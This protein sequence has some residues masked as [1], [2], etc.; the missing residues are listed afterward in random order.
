M[1]PTIT[2][3]TDL[4]SSSLC[5]ALE[6]ACKSNL[7]DH[8]YFFPRP[9][10][11]YKFLADASLGHAVFAGSSALAHLVEIWPFDV[12]Y[13][14]ETFTPNDTDLFL[15]NRPEG[16]RHKNFLKNIDIV[17]MTEK[18]VEELLMNFD[19]PICRVAMDVE[20]SIWVS[21]QALNAIM[22]GEYYIP[23][24]FIDKTEFSKLLRKHQW[25]QNTLAIPDWNRNAPLLPPETMLFERLQGRIGKY[26]GRG[27]SPCYV[28]TDEV[29]PWIKQRF[30]Y[31]DWDNLVSLRMESAPV[32]QP[33]Y[34]LTSIAEALLADPTIRKVF[35]T[36]GLVKSNEL[37]TASASNST[38]QS[39]TQSATP[40]VTDALL[41]LFGALTTQATTSTSSLKLGAN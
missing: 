40:Q 29:M 39:T 22:T 1:F 41:K 18:S 32:P 10:E 36:Y 35:T 28:R 5:T 19:L 21:A 7:A 23:Q 25:N 38:T 2:K 27:F 31:V 16:G 37:P 24:Y 13:R 33:K 11:S 26:V 30:C 34:E 9:E 3:L 4:R 20:Y 8:I 14:A 6:V 15:L 17:H 12:P